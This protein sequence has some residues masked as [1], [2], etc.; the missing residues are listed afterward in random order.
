MSISIADIAKSLDLPFKGNGSIKIHRI[1][2]WEDADLQSLIYCD[3]VR[4]SL[5]LPDKLLAGCIVTSK[6][7]FRPTWNAIISEK[8]KVVDILIKKRDNNLYSCP[9]KYIF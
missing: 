9:K 3:G 1:S 8:P 4:K 5:Q 6:D 2:N 7:F